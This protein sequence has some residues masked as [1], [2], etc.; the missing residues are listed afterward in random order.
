MAT[1]RSFGLGKRYVV[2]CNQYAANMK[3]IKG[4]NREWKEQGLV[5]EERPLSMRAPQPPIAKE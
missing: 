1:R 4:V 3:L 2:H 5:K